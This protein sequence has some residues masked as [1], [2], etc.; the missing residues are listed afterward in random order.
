MKNKTSFFRGAERIS[1]DL[2]AAV[3]AAFA[4]VLFVVYIV[5]IGP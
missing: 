5:T 2:C 1:S 4:A 3:F